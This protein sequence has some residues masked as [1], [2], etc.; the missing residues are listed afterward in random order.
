MTRRPL[1]LAGGDVAL[2]RRTADGRAVVECLDWRGRPLGRFQRCHAFELRG[3]GWHLAAIKRAIAALP[4]DGSPVLAPEP[5]APRPLLFAHH[6]AAHL[7][8]D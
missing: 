5:V 7:R 1:T 3:L 6:V 2:R 4:L 8:E